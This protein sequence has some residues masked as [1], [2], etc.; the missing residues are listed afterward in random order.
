MRTA[1]RALLVFTLVLAAF[2]LRVVVGGEREIAASTASLDRGDVHGAIEHARTS[3]LFYA[4][5]AP[6]V[7]VAYARL[8]AI[9]EEA[10]RRREWDLA[11]LA[12][13]SVTTASHSTKWVVSPRAEDAS[14]AAMSVERLEQKRAG[15]AA[16][17]F[18]LPARPL[19]RSATPLRF[20]LP[21]AFGAL[22]CGLV[23]T[24]R[25]GL[26]ESGRVRLGAAAPGLAITLVGTALYVV[27][28]VYA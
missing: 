22:V 20:S 27:A 16:E 8:L 24:L 5:G 26:D 2:T 3:A 1:L 6:H 17:T 7:R 12:F 21:A 23:L 11:L 10:E 19:V 18:D 28:L 9:G 13:R 15:A 4:P 14:V 25:R